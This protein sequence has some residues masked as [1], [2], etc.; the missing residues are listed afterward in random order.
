MRKKIST[1]NKNYEKPEF[2]ITTVCDCYTVRT[3]KGSTSR[4]ISIPLHICRVGCKPLSFTSMYLIVKSL[5]ILTEMGLENSS[6]EPSRSRLIY[7]M[8]FQ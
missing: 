8:V 7:Y 4:M 5:F 3:A 6:N 1:G 2:F